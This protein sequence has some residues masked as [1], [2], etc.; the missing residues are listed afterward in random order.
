[1]KVLLVGPDRSVKG[2][3]TTVID[4]IISSDL[5]KNHIFEHLST[6]RD[7]LTKFGKLIYGIMA[8][9]HF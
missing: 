2:G 4:G 1:M 7:D 6:H 3:I 8:Y 9:L 5:L